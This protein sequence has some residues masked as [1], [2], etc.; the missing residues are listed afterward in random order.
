MSLC[1]CVI[2][3]PYYILYS[4]TSQCFR[5]SLVTSSYWSSNCVLLPILFPNPDTLFPY[6]FFQYVFLIFL[7]PLTMTSHHDLL[8]CPFTSFYSFH[9]ILI[10][11]MHCWFPVFLLSFIL[12]LPAL[13]RCSF[14]VFFPL[15]YVPIFFL[16]AFLF[17]G[18]LSPTG[19][20]IIVTQQ[21]NKHKFAWFCFW[22][23]LYREQYLSAKGNSKPL[24]SRWREKREQKKVY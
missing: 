5:V 4:F 19:L 2:A 20:R 18:A 10:L 9:H 17:R 12:L 16:V 6:K 22:N 13:R 1:H 15:Y 21:V 7:Y 8:P 14:G 23:C 11:S 24:I 3:C